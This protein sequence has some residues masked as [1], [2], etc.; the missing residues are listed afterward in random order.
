MPTEAD[1]QIRRTHSFW[2][3]SSKE[4]VGRSWVY[5]RVLGLNDHQQDLV[6]VAEYRGGI[7]SRLTE[8]ACGEV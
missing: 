4:L 1:N 8:G 2:V 5:L 6:D 7:H 3:V